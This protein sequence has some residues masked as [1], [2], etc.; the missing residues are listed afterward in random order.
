MGTGHQVNISGHVSD[1]NPS[2]ILVALSGHVAANVTTNSSGN[3]SYSG[4]ASSLGTESALATDSQNLSSDTVQTQIVDNPPVV[5]NLSVAETGSG[6]NVLV[7]GQVQSASP[8][9]LTVSLWG[10]V[11]ASPVTNSSGTF[12]VT[13]QAAALGTIDASTTDIWGVGSATTQT[14][15]TN[16]AP[17]VTVSATETGPNRTLT[18]S[19]HVTDSVEAG[20]V[21]TISGIVSGT[22]T[23]DSSG[24]YS[25]V[26]QASG[27][28]TLSVSATDIW[29]LVSTVVK[30]SY[31]SKAPVIT[32]NASVSNGGMYV[33]TGTVTDEV[34]PG[35]TVTL[36]GVV[37]GS[38]TVRAD[39]TFEYDS[40]LQYG[41][42]DGVEYATVT[43]WWGNTSN[44]A[45]CWVD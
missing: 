24:N 8:G 25:L 21:V 43:D 6:K 20:A 18:V 36:S 30:T 39:G 44:T 34:A 17:G 7:T 10:E 16:A 5:A 41:A 11:T 15:L 29:G 33:F 19:G 27:Q 26:A 42:A 4:T 14:Q 3:F 13:T 23:T 38:C 2:G 22:A 1:Q 31:A 45:Q 40:S 35:L 9:G 37:G 28:G 32:L 12:S